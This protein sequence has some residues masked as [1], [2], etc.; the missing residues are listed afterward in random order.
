[1]KH[2]FLKLH[3]FLLICLFLICALSIYN[4][5]ATTGIHAKN[6]HI[7]QLYW[8]LIGF[9]VLVVVS[10]VDYLTLQRFTP[11]FYLAVNMALVLVLVIGKTVNGSKRWIDLGFF[12]FQPSE[13][14]K[15]ATILMLALYL[16]KNQSVDGFRLRD[17]MPVFLILLPLVV[18]IFVEPDLGHTLMI[19]FIAGSMLAYEP[20]RKKTL[21]L[22]L[23]LVVVAVPVS[24][25]FLLKSYQKERVLTLL[26]QKEIDQFGSNWHSNQAV[27]AVGSG[28]LMGKGHGLGTQVAG[29]FLP[30]N[31]TDFVFA[32]WTE[33][34]GFL[35]GIFVLMIYFGIVL[36]AFYT[37][38]TMKDRFGAQVAIGVGAMIFWNVFMNTGM[39]IG[40]LP[41]TGVTLPLMTYGGTS[42]I[43]V[44]MGLGLLMNVH[45]HRGDF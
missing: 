44:M 23:L 37:A 35:G 25:Q 2:F 7:N 30:E 29:G 18:L 28:G 6:V 38:H 22:L 3:W 5:H 45:A 20:F 12:T 8:F 40:L 9:G 1:M 4:L 34:Q 11:Y 43:T 16:K 42:A 33:E 31:H 27:I 24:W 13:L 41:V 36:S 14:A 17:L 39:V 10:S 21:V 26:D 19:F 15:L 32:K